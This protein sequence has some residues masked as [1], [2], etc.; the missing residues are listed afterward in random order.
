MKRE[1]FLAV[2]GAMLAEADAALLSEA[3]GLVFWRERELRTEMVRLYAPGQIVDWREPG[4]FTMR[5]IIDHL[6]AFSLSV[7]IGDGQTKAVP[8]EWVHGL[9]TEAVLPN[10]HLGPGVTPEAIAAQ[11]DRYVRGRN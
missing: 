4:G 3:K 8:I 9:S 2:F 10:E 5:S 11:H 6:N 1:T 7:K